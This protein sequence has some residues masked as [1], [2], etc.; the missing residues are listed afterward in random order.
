[1]ASKEFTLAVEQRSKLGT[2]GAQALRAAGKVP[3]VLYGH[4]VVA[5]HLAM[6][7]HDFEEL[8]H[9]AG[10]NAILTLTDGERKRQTA[11]VREIQRH[12]VSRRVVH[13]DLQRVSADETID[14]RLAIVTVGVAE[15]VR[16]SG[17]VMEVITHELEIS[18]P[19][20]QIPEHLEISVEHLGVYEHVTAGEIALPPGLRLLTPPETV[21]VSVAPSR[22]AR[23]LEEAAAPA[24]EAAEP[25]VIGAAEPAAPEAQ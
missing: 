4:G 9:R 8:I 22:T 25:E 11:L 23:E 10:R 5:E 19:V 13:A 18:G 16:N 20:N 14:A 15:G 2:T 1:V 3:A 12:P 17:A 6:N 7:A 24:G 21:V